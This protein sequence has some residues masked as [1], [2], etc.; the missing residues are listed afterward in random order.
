MG[1][2]DSAMPC[3]VRELKNLIVGVIV[4]V[5]DAQIGI[6]A[7][8]KLDNLQDGSELAAQLLL[9]TNGQH[10]GAVASLAVGYIAAGVDVLQ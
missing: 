6:K 1:F 3:K 4:L 5:K 10:E 7:I 9:V 8:G 2:A